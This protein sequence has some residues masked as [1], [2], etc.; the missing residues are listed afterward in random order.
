MDIAVNADVDI[1]SNGEMHI[2]STTS[3]EKGLQLYR[4]QSATFFPETD[5][6][7]PM[8]ANIKSVSY[9]TSNST[10]LSAAVKSNAPISKSEK[11][12]GLLLIK[13]ERKS[14]I[15]QLIQAFF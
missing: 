6:H 8:Y 2:I 9:P 5:H 4:G 1:D 10:Q 12:H 14:L 13:G 11:V 15:S 7:A 3:W